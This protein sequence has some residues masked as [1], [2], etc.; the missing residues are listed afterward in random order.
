MDCVD[1]SGMERLDPERHGGLLALLGEFA[2]CVSDEPVLCGV[3]GV[4]LLFV[5]LVCEMV[6]LPCLF[7]TVA[8]RDDGYFGSCVSILSNPPCCSGSKRSIPL[9]STFILG[10]T[11]LSIVAGTSTRLKSTSFALI[12]SQLCTRV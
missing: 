1:R 12:L 3:C 5:F 2:A 11:S 4:W 7:S 6:R 9:R 8:V 10:N